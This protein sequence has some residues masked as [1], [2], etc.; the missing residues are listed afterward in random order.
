MAA[1]N[2][3]EVR[4]ELTVK[5]LVLVSNAPAPTARFV[6]PAALVLSPP[7]IMLPPSAAAAVFGATIEPAS[8]APAATAPPVTS[9]RRVER[10]AVRSSD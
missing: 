8:A 7:M 5:A 3:L 1:G 6:S 4:P 9:A 10:L 2:E